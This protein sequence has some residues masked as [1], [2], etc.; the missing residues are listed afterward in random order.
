MDLSPPSA[1]GTYL[2][3]IFFSGAYL[4]DTCSCDMIHLHREE[5][6]RYIS[7]GIRIGELATKRPRPHCCNRISFVVKTES[8]LDG[9]TCEHMSMTLLLLMW[10]RPDIISTDKSHAFH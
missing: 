5:I 6:P 8:A 2:S 4:F 7:V 1:S 10:C 9:G 3:V